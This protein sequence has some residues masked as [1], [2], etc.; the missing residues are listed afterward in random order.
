MKVALVYR[1]PQVT[2]AEAA[3]TGIGKVVGKFAAKP[4]RP[5]D[6]RK[7]R[8]GREGKSNARIK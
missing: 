2:C 1:N 3:L 8:Q 5:G 7:G 4:I 6:N